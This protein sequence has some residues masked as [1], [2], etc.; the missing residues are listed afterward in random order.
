MF[1]EKDGMKI[2]SRWAYWLP[3][4]LTGSG[5]GMAARIDKIVALTQSLSKKASS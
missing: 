4:G 2:A 1:I 5:F 3:R